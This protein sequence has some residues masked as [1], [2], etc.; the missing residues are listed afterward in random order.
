M[1]NV[2]L[3]SRSEAR[4]KTGEGGAQTEP[5]QVDLMLWRI[6]ARGGQVSVWN[7]LIEVDGLNEGRGGRVPMSEMKGV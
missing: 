4:E 3:W 6:V 2:Y 1:S 5:E 7:G